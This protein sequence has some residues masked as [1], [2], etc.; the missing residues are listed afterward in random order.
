MFPGRCRDSPNLCRSSANVHM[1]PFHGPCARGEQIIP[2]TF[3]SSSGL[4]KART[5][6]DQRHFGQRR[7]RTPKGSQ[8][9]SFHSP[10]KIK[11]LDHVEPS[12]PSD[13]FSE[14][15]A[16]LADTAAN[17]CLRKAGAFLLIPEQ[18]HQLLVWQTANRFNGLARH[19]HTVKR[20][21]LLFW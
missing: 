5:R 20:C 7:G 16:G 3:G 17:L 1:G 19:S 18:F 6:L 8:R 21:M 12:R 9:V 11:E 13:H 4:R 2:S 10:D 14:V 15:A